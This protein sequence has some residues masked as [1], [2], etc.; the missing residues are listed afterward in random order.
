MDL[1]DALRQL[2]EQ[3]LSGVA[4]L[5]AY[6][7]TW[8]VCAVFWSRASQRT[9]A[10][11]TLFQGMVAFPIALGLSALI[12]AIGQS[13]P[14]PEEITQFSI[15]V[16]TSQLLGLPLLIYLIIKRHYGLVPVVFATITAVHFVLY[17][18]LYQTPL[19]IGMAVLIALSTTA[20]MGA[21]DEANPRSGPGRVCL[22]T[23]S[24]LLLTAAVFAGMHLTAS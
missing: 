9:A 19:Y 15:L 10:Y 22:V 24:L 23:G 14:V 8:L 3:N 12:G 13:R 16:G 7:L 18:W 4:F 21:A 2:A 17:S 6:G 20:V 5:S 11:A 1:A